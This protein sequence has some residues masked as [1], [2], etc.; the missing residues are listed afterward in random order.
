MSF[1][2]SSYKAS[3]AEPI[4]QEKLLPFTQSCDKSQD[5][6]DSYQNREGN[7]DVNLGPSSVIS[8]I[9]CDMCVGGENFR[10]WFE[11]ISIT[12]QS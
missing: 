4:V 5:D 8:S 7:V 11:D 3:Q 1:P 6:S 9:H 10:E 2:G 12:D